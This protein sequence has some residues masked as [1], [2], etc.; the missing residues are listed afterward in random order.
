M[1]LT[2]NLKSG[3]L[4]LEPDFLYPL[5]NVTIL[6]ERNATFT[7]IFPTCQ[8]VTSCC[9]ARTV[10][11]LPVP[12]GEP[13]GLEPD[14]LY[15]LKNVTTLQERNATFTSIFPTSLGLEPDFLYPLENVTIPQ[16]RDAIFT[17]IFPTCQHV[18]SCCSAR[19]GAGLPVPSGEPLGLEPDFLYPL[20]NVT[21]P[22]GR[23]AIFTCVVNNLGGYRVAWIKADTKAILAIHEHV[24]TNNQRLSV[25]HNDFNT[26][27]LNIRGVKREDRGTYMCQVNTDPMKSQM[28]FLEVVIPPDI[29]YE[30]TSGDMMVPEGGSAKL[31]CKAR[32]FPK[33]KVV[34]RREDGGDIIVRSPGKTKSTSAV[35]H[36][37]TVEGEVL[38]LNKVTR[39]EMGAYLCIAANGVPPSVSKR[40]MLHVHFHPLI[41]VPNQLVGAPTSTDV[42]LLCHVEASPKAINYWTRETGEM[43][44]SNDKYL[45]SEESSSYY[46][47]AMKL[48]IQDFQKSDLGGYKC[49]SKN[50]IGDAEGNIR[51]YEVEVKRPPKSDNEED[52]E[53]GEGQRLTNGHQGP[54]R[55]GEEKATEGLTTDGGQSSATRRLYSLGLLA[56]TLLHYL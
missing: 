46:S 45:M 31:V 9:S 47:T 20:E 42:P 32:G 44:I 5:E 40:M 8:H 1:N 30:E 27:T 41:Q 22:Q 33:P 15:F 19:T 29:I 24:I 36:V 7:S 25:T 48:V 52:N 13:L 56:S 49:I 28:A 51:L 21:I 35:E 2:C 11:G 3:T 17:S 34:W 38:T 50:S 37:A 39:S 53:L 16:G 26:W 6:Q 55:E 14:F 54:L 43:I 23:D 10:A 18:T 4:G 12:S